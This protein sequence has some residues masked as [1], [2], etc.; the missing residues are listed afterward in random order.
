MNFLLKL[1]AVSHDPMLQKLGFALQ[2]REL[3]WK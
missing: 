2:R 3:K 1:A